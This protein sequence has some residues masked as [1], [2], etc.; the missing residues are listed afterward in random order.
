MLPQ[1]L[2][3]EFSQS[4]TR[5]EVFGIIPEFTDE[6]MIAAWEFFAPSA[7][8]EQKSTSNR[9]KRKRRRK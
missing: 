6:R 9:S 4:V 3:F 8:K 5:Y 2:R 7:K 1:E